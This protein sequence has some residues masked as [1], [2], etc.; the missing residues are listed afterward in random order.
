[1]CYPPTIARVGLSG[2]Y[3]VPVTERQQ[4]N[5]HPILG[6]KICSDNSLQ[7]TLA[8]ICPERSRDGW[9]SWWTCARGSTG[10]GQP[11]WPG[12]T[13]RPS[14]RGTPAGGHTSS[15]LCLRPGRPAGKVQGAAVPV[16]GAAHWAQARLLADA[17]WARV[18]ERALLSEMESLPCD[19]VWDQVRPSLAT[20]RYGLLRRWRGC[21]SLLET[22]QVKPTPLSHQ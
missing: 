6:P 18:Q 10:S 12:S 13:R 5:V 8:D 21:G 7:I 16:A 1:M 17:I 19:P 15:S 3:S 14:A 2:R 20:A 11:R 9:T 22:F 4:L